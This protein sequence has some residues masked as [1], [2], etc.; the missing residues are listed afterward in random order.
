MRRYLFLMMLVTTGLTALAQP[1]Q[2]KSFFVNACRFYG[3]FSTELKPIC[4]GF[5]IHIN[6][7]TINIGEQTDLKILSREMVDNKIQFTLKDTKGVIIGAI[8]GVTPLGND[9]IQ[10]VFKSKK[11][12]GVIFQYW[13]QVS[14]YDFWRSMR[15][16]DK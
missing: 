14:A 9:Y 15:N 12:S 10:L 6:Q 1:Q 5:D 13:D 11:E 3:D 8:L 2:Q 7:S 4:Q 16:K